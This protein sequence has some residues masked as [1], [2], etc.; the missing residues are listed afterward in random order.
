MTFDLSDE[1]PVRSPNRPFAEVADAFLSRRSVLAGGLAAAVAG[2]IGGSA[3]LAGPAGAAAPA[4]SGRPRPGLG[5]TRVP[6]GSADALVVPP[7]YTAQVLIPWGSPLFSDVDWKPDASNTAAD[8]ARQVGSNHDG[9][10]YFPLARGPEGS[11]R[12]LLVLNHEYVDPQLMTPQGRGDDGRGPVTFDA[13]AKEVEAHGVT[14]VEVRR[15]RNGSWRYVVD[16]PYNRRIT[17]TTPMAFS[18]PVSAGHPWLQAGDPTPKG[19]LNNCAMGY[20]PWDTYLTCEENWNGYFGTADTSW[21]ANPVEAS[22]GVTAGGFGYRWHEGDPRFDLAT[23]RNELNRFGWVVEI[24]PFNPGST[25]VKRT[26]LGRFK[27]EGALVVESRGRAVVYSGDDENREYVYKF[28]G[29]MPWRS[30]VARRQSPLD[31]GT[32]YVAK[33]NDDGTGTWLPLVHGEG[34]LTVANGWV[35]QADVLLRT[36]LAADA[37]GATPMDRPEWVTQDPTTGDIYF[38]MTNGSS[39]GA[40][41]GN[42][43]NPTVTDT[44]FTGNVYGNIVKIVEEGTSTSFEWDLWMLCGDPVYQADVSTPAGSDIFGSPDGIWC[45]PDGRLWIQTDVSNS[46]QNRPE[47]GHDRL[48]NNQMLVAD[49]VTKEVKRFLVGPRGCE[50]TGVITTP[51]QRTMFINVQHPGEA[52]TFWG[53]PTPSNPTAVSSWPALPSDDRPRSATVVIRRKDGGIIGT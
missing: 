45:D 18:G 16:S 11:E 39:G 1:H 48:G 8:Q 15:N 41:N 40:A 25:P 20:T 21:A 26:A 52:T 14:V 32:L 51:D 49:T 38:T 50:I 46:T 19:T 31:H 4:I 33:F 3:V 27:H 6:A 5:F 47:R 7:E 28:I 24:D 44:R 12:G 53:A 2:F 43:P 23:N 29:D 34:P 42:R 17:G 30:R 37:L 35:D 10:H 22:Y 36:R 9:M 13:V